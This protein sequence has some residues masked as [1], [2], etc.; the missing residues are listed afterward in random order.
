MPSSI[1]QTERHYSQD[2]YFLS[3]KT[4]RSAILLIQVNKLPMNSP[5]SNSQW[6]LNKSTD[7][8]FVQG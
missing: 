4:L 1:C 6:L 3:L 5:V 2:R 7:N 8:A